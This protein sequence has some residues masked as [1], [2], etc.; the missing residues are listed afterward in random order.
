MPETLPVPRAGCPLIQV[1]GSIGFTWE[2]RAPSLLQ[3]RALWIEAHGGYPRELGA[4]R[5]LA[6]L[7]D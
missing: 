5:S 1:L 2:A 4:R 3:A 6:W 7:L